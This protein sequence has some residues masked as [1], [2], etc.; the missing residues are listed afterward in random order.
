MPR[1]IEQPKKGQVLWVGD[2]RLRVVAI[3]GDTVLLRIDAP[4]G[5]L[6]RIDDSGESETIAD[7]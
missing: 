6:V 3:R 1:S 4:D 5:V 2:V 7:D